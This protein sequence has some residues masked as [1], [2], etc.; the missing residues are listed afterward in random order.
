MSHLNDPNVYKP[1]REDISLILKEQIIDK[2][3]A[4]KRNGFLKQTWFDF[5]KPPKHTRTSRLYFLKKIHKNPMG[6]RPIVSSCNSITEPIS[7]FVDKWLQPHVKTLPSY[8]KDTTEFLKLIE[9]TKLPQNCILASIDVS[10]LYTNI[11]HKDGKQSVL[12]FLQHNPDNYSR[13]EQPIPEILTELIEI[14]LKNNVF[15]FN[16]NYYLQIQGTAMGTK[17]APAYANLFM[18]KLEEKLRELGKPH[19]MP[20]KRFIDDTFVIW[21]GSASE[22]TTYMNTINQIH[23]TIKFTYDVS[24]TELTFLDVTLY[25]G[26]RFSLNQLL[27]VRTHIKPTN[28]QLYVHATSYHP[29]TTIN[30]I[31][32]G[33]ANR[34]LR[35]NSNEKGFQNMKQR[36]TNRL[37]QRGY[38]HKQVLPHLNAV[39]FNQRHQIL[40]RNKPKDNKKKL[41]FVT[42]FCDDAH[43]LK[44]IL[45]KHWKLIKNNK[46]LNHIFPEPPVIAYRNHPS[47]KHK[48]VRAKLKSIDEPTQS[49]NTQLNPSKSAH[50]TQPLPAE[51][52]QSIFKSSLQ[53]FRNPIRRCCYACAICPSFETRCFAEST[54]FKHK[55]PIDIPNPK[56]FFN[57]RTKNVIYLVICTTP[58]CRAQYVG[59]TTRQIISRIVEH[60]DKGP[61]INHIKQE[62]HEYKRIRFQILAQ[63]PSQETNKELWL[64]R[65]EYLW[66]CRLGTSNKLSNKGLNKLIYDPIF[67]SNTET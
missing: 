38:K 17:M 52:P 61:M 8:L 41:V 15:E 12:H 25:K 16:N 20:C 46:T 65:H 32:K 60:L 42:H 45:K 14:V 28:K 22:F 33:E 7:Q 35:T 58:G 27:D 48:L 64:K 57:C 9:T 47:L 1:L 24:E 39:K 23:R 4:L 53:N 63:A 67:H 40:F 37:L 59:Y 3:G 26:N 31:S 18:G 6:I 49:G 50:T 43:R 13:P 2:L 30:A 44:Q 10:S 36:L 62:N 55:F 54:T 34:Y 5:C 11:P 19:I 29:P 51:Y 21:T 66:I 56:Q